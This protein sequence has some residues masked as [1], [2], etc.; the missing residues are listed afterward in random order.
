M[1]SKELIFWII[2]SV[3]LGFIGGL[4]LGIDLGVDNW[5]VGMIER[6]DNSYSNRITVIDGDRHI[7]VMEVDKSC[8]YAELIYRC[9]TETVEARKR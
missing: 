5:E 8:E 6:L 3:I 7:T 9:E 2:V 4:Y 1:R